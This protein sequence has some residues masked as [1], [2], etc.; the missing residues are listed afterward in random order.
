MVE[1]MPEREPE[2]TVRDSR[3]YRWG[4]SRSDVKTMYHPYS[5]GELIVVY[6]IQTKFGNVIIPRRPPLDLLA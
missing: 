2:F 3:G 4:Y 6:Y 1:L 5:S